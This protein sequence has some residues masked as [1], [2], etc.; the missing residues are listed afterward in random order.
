ML[1]LASTALR[2][3]MAAAAAWH[4]QQQDRRQL[5]AMGEAELRDLGIGRG[6][7]PGVLEATAGQS[8]PR[9][10]AIRS[11]AWVRARGERAL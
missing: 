9:H 8:A 1:P 2:R 4:R 11:E 10:T 3:F 5:M 7:I 6:Q